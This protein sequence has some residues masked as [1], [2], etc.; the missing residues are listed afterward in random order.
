M[1]TGDKEIILKFSNDYEYYNVIS[2]ISYIVENVDDPMVIY[3][4]VEQILSQ[5]I[6]EE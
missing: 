3:E 4:E 2:E 1:E 5:F 6:E